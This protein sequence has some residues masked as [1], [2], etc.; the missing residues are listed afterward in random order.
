MGVDFF[1]EGQ[2]SFARK[3][4]ASARPRGMTGLII[5]WGLARNVSGAQATLL[6]VAALALVGAAFLW[7]FS[8]SSSRV[9]PD[10]AQSVLEEMRR[11]AL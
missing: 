1:E 10:E 6:I 11:E 5:S 9:S 8:F 4:S 2:G 3:V 7:T